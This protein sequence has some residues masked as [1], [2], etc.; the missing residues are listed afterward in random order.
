MDPDRGGVSHGAPG[1]R[2]KSTE[3][4]VF[5]TLPERHSNKLRQ[6]T[7][8]TEKRGKGMKTETEGVTNRDEGFF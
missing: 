5:I 6:L 7:G 1:W 4:D 2:R 8:V 3:E